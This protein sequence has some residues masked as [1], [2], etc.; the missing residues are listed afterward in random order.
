[1]PRLR[2]RP[3]R[4]SAVIISQAR[5]EAE[6]G[7][8]HNAQLLS[9]GGDGLKGKKGKLPWEVTARG[10]SCWWMEGTREGVQGGGGILK[11]VLKAQMGQPGREE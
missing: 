2:P 5:P 9:T 8:G 10:T 1:M 4:G 11:S 7:P 3:H 6:V